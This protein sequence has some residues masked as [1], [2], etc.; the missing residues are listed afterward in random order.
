MFS[1]SAECFSWLNA[2]FSREW[3]KYYSFVS[4]LSVVLVCG[5]LLILTFSFSSSFQLPYTGYLSISTRT[6]HKLSSSFCNRC[7]SE[8]MIIDL[9]TRCFDVPIFHCIGAWD[10]QFMYRFVFVSFL[11]IIVSSFL[12]VNLLTETTK[13]VDTSKICKW[14]EFA[15]DKCSISSWSYISCLAWYTH[16][17][18]LFFPM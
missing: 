1:H 14:I 10:F 18:H 15:V 3:K 4:L 16:T 8:D 6:F 2:L 11:K 5:W 13:C 12:L 7:W 9:L 17:R